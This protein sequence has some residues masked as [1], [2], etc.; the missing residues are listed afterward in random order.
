M[1]ASVRRPAKGRLMESDMRLVLLGPPGAG[2]GTQAFKLSQILAIAQLSTGDMLRAAVAAGTAPGREAGG[3]I[4]GGGALPGQP[5]G[6]V[7]AGRI[8]SPDP[9]KRGVPDGLPR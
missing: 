1:S 8:V 9:A 5:G 7:V 2:K 3:E 6:G 4:G